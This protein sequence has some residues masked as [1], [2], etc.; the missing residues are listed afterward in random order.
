MRA[1]LTAGR[2]LRVPAVALGLVVSGLLGV[3][4]TAVAQG[5][6]SA[7]TAPK[8]ELQVRRA[9]NFD[10]DGGAVRFD[11]EFSGARANACE[12]LGALDYKIVTSPENT[13]IN[14]S[15]WYAFRVTSATE[16]EITV[17]IVVTASK[18][19]PRPYI[20]I[21]GGPFMRVASSAYEG[22]EGA[23]ECVLRL[24]VGPRPTLVASN[25]MIGIAE[26]EAW[27]DAT[28]AALGVKPREIGR[29]AGDRPIRAF[30]F[31]AS[32]AREA[33]IVIGRQHPP[34]VAGTVGLF[35]FIEA[36]AAD[37]DTARAF[38][39]R[40]RVLCV[41][42]VNPDGV[43]EGQWRS[44]LGAVDANR[45]WGPFTQAETRLVR[46]AILAFARE[47]ERTPRLLLDFHA[48]SKDIFYVPPDDTPLEPPHF[49]SRW[50]AAITARFPDYAVESSA[51][52]NVKEWTFKRWAFETFRAPG[53]T[54]ELGTATPHDRIARIVP[55]AAEEAMKLLLAE[56][57]PRAAGAVGS[58]A[59]AAAAP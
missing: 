42:L 32:D 1:F 37:T 12:R 6:A 19:R 44:T 49:A 5:T 53:I 52:N 45:D 48:T 33:V 13:P 4:P 46:D 3:V 35:R 58:H 8:A 31:G 27:T 23:R 59:P 9:W 22:G 21:D 34:E 24:R 20:S 47:R 50:L 36:L 56:P 25:H 18:A 7:A 29:S 16:R 51:T 14:P 17:R 41:P 39:T 38:R 40:F 54:Y 55:G 30:E 43:H 57:A 2:L 10:E 28:T 11:N 15:P 26:I